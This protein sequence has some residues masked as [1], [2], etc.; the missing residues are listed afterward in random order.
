M[1]AANHSLRFIRRKVD[2]LVAAT[3]IANEGFPCVF[4]AIVTSVT[5]I[6]GVDVVKGKLTVNE[7]AVGEEYTF[8]YDRAGGGTWLSKT[9][10]PYLKVGSKIFVR[11][12]VPPNASP[13]A[14]T[15]KIIVRFQTLEGASEPVHKTTEGKG[16]LVVDTRDGV[17]H[18]THAD[19]G[20]TDTIK[21]HLSIVYGMYNYEGHLIPSYWYKW[22]DGNWMP[23]EPG[24]GQGY[25]GLRVD[26][27]E[28]GHIYLIG[29]YD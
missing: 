19:A 25:N 4:P 3:E 2:P 1:N 17:D 20:P 23:C 26:Y 18:V 24:A 16:W 7:V 10:V 21:P 13:E 12:Y 11:L 6:G 8:A 22:H 29:E 27:D 14:Y 28:R 9:L 15:Y 5:E